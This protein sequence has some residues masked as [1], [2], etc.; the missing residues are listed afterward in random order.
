M[1]EDAAAG[2]WTAMGVTKRPSEC[3]ISTYVNH[4]SIISSIL[5]LYV[6]GYRSAVAVAPAHWSGPRVVLAVG[7]ESC[8]FALATDDD[9]AADLD[10]SP[11]ADC[12]GFT[13]VTFPKEE[14]AKHAF[15]SG[16]EGRIARVL[17]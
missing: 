16:V 7:K 13:S 4:H 6:G 3:R 2:E 10:F 5:D 11:V 8:D 1:T 15:A 14:G 17:I 12:T 9:G